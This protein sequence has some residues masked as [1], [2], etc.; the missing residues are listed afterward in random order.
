MFSRVRIWFGLALGK[1]SRSQVRSASS[2]AQLGD[3]RVRKCCV[4]LGHSIGSFRVQAV[5]KTR[6]HEPKETA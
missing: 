2:A 6:R 1:P 5:S 4:P 3:T